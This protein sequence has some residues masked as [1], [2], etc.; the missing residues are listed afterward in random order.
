[1]A[2]GVDP[3]RLRELFGAHRS[4]WTRFETDGTLLAIGPME[5]PS[6]GALA[7]FATREAAEE[8][9]QGDPFV[10]E[11]VV[12]RWEV[13]GWQEAILESPDEKDTLRTYLQRGREAVLWKLEGLSPY[14]ARRPVVPTGSNLLGLVK[15]LAAIEFGYLGLVFGRTPEGVPAW[16]FDDA[17][18]DDP[19][20][21]MYAK[22]DESV[23]DVVALYRAA[24]AHGDATIEALS[25]DAKGSVP[26]WPDERRTVTLH[27]ILVHLIAET[28]RHAGHA[29]LLRE[30]IDGQAGMRPD[31]LNLPDLGADWWPR[32]VEKLEQIAREAGE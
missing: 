15:H 26:W 6:D 2:A 31:A 30:L 29:D 27:R 8:F 11:G 18:A 16:V 12:G 9:A 24:W 25:L 5:S 3:A 14:D 13:T 32:Y 17:P 21:D 4:R 22:V 28:H 1:M 10:T 23:A 20:V 7:V 19:N